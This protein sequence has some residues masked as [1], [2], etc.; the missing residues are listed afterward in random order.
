MIYFECL[1][2]SCIF[3]EKKKSHRSRWLHQILIGEI[4][5]SY[6]Y[7]LFNQFVF[8][9]L[10]TTQILKAGGCFPS[11]FCICILTDKLEFVYFLLYTIL[12]KPLLEAPCVEYNKFIRFAV[13][14]KYG[15]HGEYYPFPSDVLNFA[16]RQD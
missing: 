3:S 11:A 6:F 2:Q 8:S 1:N 9:L 10:P 5:I 12:T 16:H 13:F 15:C 14:H 4:V 7:E